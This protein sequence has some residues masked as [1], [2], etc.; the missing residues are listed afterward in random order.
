M[1]IAK[2][3]AGAATALALIAAATLNA[4]ARAE[5]PIEEA[6]I[7]WWLAPAFL[8]LLAALAIANDHKDIRPVSP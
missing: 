7:S 4:P 8:S 5:V 2:S 1:A 3:F 6:A